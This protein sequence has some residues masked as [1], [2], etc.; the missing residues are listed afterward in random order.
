M[1]AVIWCI[2]GLVVCSLPFWLPSLVVRVRNCV[3]VSM[4]GSEGLG[5]GRAYAGTSLVW[6][7]GVGLAAAAARRRRTWSMR[8]AMLPLLPG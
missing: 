3:F 4:N 2:A 6:G 8:Q 7:A 5:R 1:G